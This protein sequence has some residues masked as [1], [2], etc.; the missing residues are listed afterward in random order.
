MFCLVVVVCQMELVTWMTQSQEHLNE[1][2]YESVEKNLKKS[3]TDIQILDLTGGLSQ[4]EFSQTLNRGE[5]FGIFC[6]L[7]KVLQSPKEKIGNE[8]VL[9]S[10][11][12][13]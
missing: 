5:K 10:I 6:L 11:H 13:N 8:R 2:S 9:I 3:E 1:Y 7:C 12:E 4:L